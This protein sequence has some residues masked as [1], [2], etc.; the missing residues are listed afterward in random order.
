MCVC[1]CVF[2]VVSE[3]AFFWLSFVLMYTHTHTHTNTQPNKA[4]VGANAFAHESGIHQDGMLKNKE[5]YE[6]MDAEVRTYTYTHTHTFSGS[7]SLPNIF[8]AHAHFFHLSQP[9]T[10]THTKKKKQ[11]IGLAKN[12]LVLGKHSG[13][14]AFRAR[15]T[16]LGYELTD[17]ELNKAFVRFKELADKKKDVSSLDLESIVNDEIRLE[18][19]QGWCVY[20]CVC[21][22]V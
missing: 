10:H 15:L 7:L 14:H 12:E 13:R 21:V 6:I 16:E 5:T 17:A 2:K 18:F 8:M 9:F 4:I 1:W 19:D 20:L 3:V 22:F 11:S